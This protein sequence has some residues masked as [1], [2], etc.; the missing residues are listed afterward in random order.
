M[1]TLPELFRRL[2]SP[3]VTEESLERTATPDEIKLLGAMALNDNIILG[4]N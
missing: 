4:E 3:E 2:T 1:E